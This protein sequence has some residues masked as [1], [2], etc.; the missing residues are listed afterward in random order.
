M[1]LLREDIDSDLIYIV[2]LFFYNMMVGK[3]H[4]THVI[5]QVIKYTF[6]SKVSYQ[7][8]FKDGY[9]SVVAR[10]YRY[11]SHS[12]NISIHDMINNYFDSVIRDKKIV[13]ILTS[14]LWVED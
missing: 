10:Y 14:R 6:N 3:T 2:E 5:S 4:R 7:I 8:V 11:G 13:D 12:D 1:R 9:V